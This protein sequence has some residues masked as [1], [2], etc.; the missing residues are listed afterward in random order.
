MDHRIHFALYDGAASCPPV[1][2]FM[3]KGLDEELHVAAMDSTG[4][5]AN[6]RLE[7]D[8]GGTVELSMILNWYRKDFSSSSNNGIFLI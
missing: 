2:N 4:D 1:K 3:K 7:K 6:V 5:D 8:S